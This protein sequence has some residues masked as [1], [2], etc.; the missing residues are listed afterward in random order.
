[1]LKT[2]SPFAHLGSLRSPG[3]FGRK[4]LDNASAC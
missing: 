4:Q 2:L 1:M 3:A